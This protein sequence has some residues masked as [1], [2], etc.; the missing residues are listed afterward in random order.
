MTLCSA[1]G[2]VNTAY[3]LAFSA[4]GDCDYPESDRHFGGIVNRMSLSRTAS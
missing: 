1:F 2:A 4:R 3:I